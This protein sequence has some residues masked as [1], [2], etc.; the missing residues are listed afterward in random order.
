MPPA[1]PALPT[2]PAPTIRPCAA[3]AKPKA[4][5]AAAAVEE[6][7]EASSAQQQQPTGSVARKISTRVFPDH[8]PQAPT[9]AAP[10]APGTGGGEQAVQGEGAGER[11]LSFL[12]RTARGRAPS[13]TA[14]EVEGSG[15][16]AGLK[17]KEEK[18]E[19]GEEEAW[20]VTGRRGESVGE[21][22]GVQR[23]LSEAAAEALV[24]SIAQQAQQGD[25]AEQ[26][27]AVLEAIIEGVLWVQRPGAWYGVGWGGVR[28]ADVH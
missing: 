6:E 20:E 14:S 9:S 7:E 10:T 5:T 12:P 3:E 16:G 19:E 8:P 23:A 1:L 24:A 22:G 4:P 15:A 18:E 25:L 27:R 21:E 13:S 17:E 2:L 26:E 11:P 28:Q